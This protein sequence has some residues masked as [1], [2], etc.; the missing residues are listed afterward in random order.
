MIH[1]RTLASAMLVAFGAIVGRPANLSALS[2]PNDATVT[3]LSVVP[4]TGAGHADVV[5]RVDGTIAFKHFILSKPDKIVIDISGAT[6][7]LPA[8]DSYDGVARGGITRIRYSQFTKSVV[9]VVL[10]LDAPHDYTVSQNAGEVHVGVD[11]A[12]SKFSPWQVNGGGQK[13]EAE[14]KVAKAEAAP[15]DVTKADM[16]KPNV[17]PETRK[18]EAEQQPTASAE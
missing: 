4:A 8:G 9:R 15:A 14:T 1:H 5:I 13:V 7:G 18:V 17:K 12:G 10:T 6:L 11:G 16:A 2:T 3:S